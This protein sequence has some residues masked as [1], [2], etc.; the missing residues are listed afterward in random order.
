LIKGKVGQAKEMRK[1]RRKKQREKE[2]VF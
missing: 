1:K 2:G